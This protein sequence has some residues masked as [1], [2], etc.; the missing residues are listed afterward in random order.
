LEHL[1]SEFKVTL[2][3]CSLLQELRVCVGTGFEVGFLENPY[4]LRLFI[5]HLFKGALD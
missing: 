3:F 1:A 4:P 2:A 5:D